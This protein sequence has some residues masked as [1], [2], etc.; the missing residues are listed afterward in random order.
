MAATKPKA[1]KAKTSTTGKK[2]IKKKVGKTLTKRNSTA[3]R[4]GTAAKK[5]TNATQK[6]NRTGKLT[7][8]EQKARQRLRTGDKAALMVKLRVGSKN[9]CV[10]TPKDFFEDLERVL[11]LKFKFDPCPANASF[12]GLKV[13]WKGPAFINPPFSAIKAFVTKAV[14]E[15]DERN[16][17]SAFLIPIRAESKYW[18]EIV[19]PQADQILILQGRLVFQGYTAALP[20]S[21]A[22]VVFRPKKE[23]HKVRTTSFVKG[24][25]YRFLS[26]YAPGHESH[27]KL[28][29]KPKGVSNPSRSGCGC[30]PAEFVREVQQITGLKFTGL[31]SSDWKNAWAK[32]SF[33]F[34]PP[35]GVQPSIKKAIEER[36][37]HG[38]TSALFIPIRSETKY[39]FEDIYPEADQILYLAD[40]VHLCG[41]KNKMPVSMCVVIY[42]KQKTSSRKTHFINGANYSFISFYPPRS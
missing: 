10:S 17:T 19:W 26:I 36:D 24:N 29:P 33:V 37:K 42:R 1:K 6:V 34:P 23:C 35:S 27:T 16:I 38:V 7:L 9:D 4:I 39:T 21:L 31:Y 22:V 40:K 3:K 32:T 30:V 20:I 2:V 25:K 13:N 18:R 28:C 15:R 41:Q 11:H 8:V 14:K 12:D 5:R